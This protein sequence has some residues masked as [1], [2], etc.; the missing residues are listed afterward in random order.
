MFRNVIISLNTKSVFITF[1]HFLST[2]QLYYQTYNEHQF[3][4]NTKL[5]DELVHIASPSYQNPFETVL[6]AVQGS[7]QLYIIHHIEQNSPILCYSLVQYGKEITLL[8]HHQK[9]PV[10]FY[11]FVIMNNK[12]KNTGV[13]IKLFEYFY[14]QMQKQKE[15]QSE[16]PLLFYYTTATPSIIYLTD[17]IFK[18]TIPA[19]NDYYRKFTDDEWHIVN[20]L[21]RLRNWPIVMKSSNINPFVIKGIMKARYSTSEQMR[22]EK[23]MKKTNYKM[24]QDL[25]INEMNGNRLLRYTFI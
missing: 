15:K 10:V 25:N 11:R 16:L 24:F 5:F 21:R 2:T 8:N 1:K 17:Q 19:I 6:N 14:H 23:I 7:N 12:Y 3:Q 9:I 20:E 13:I 4:P 18:N 22:I